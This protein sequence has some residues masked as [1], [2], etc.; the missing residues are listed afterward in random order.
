MAG[1]PKDR[2]RFTTDKSL[3]KLAS[4]ISLI[5]SPDSIVF[6]AEDEG[7]KLAK[8]F[9]SNN[10]KYKRLDEIVNTTKEGRFL[11]S[12]ITVH[13]RPWSDFEEIWWELSWRLARAAKGKVH[14]FGPTR[15]IKDRPLAD[16][17]HKFTTGAYANTV[18]EKVELPEL[19]Q[20]E[21]VSEIFYNGQ[22]FK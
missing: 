14:V 3:L 15:L 8:Q 10:S 5:T 7:A 4:E 9:V 12:S 17:K 20:N 1:H 22:S 18:F 19:E 16:Y 21:N 13:N 2:I 6:Y 11:W